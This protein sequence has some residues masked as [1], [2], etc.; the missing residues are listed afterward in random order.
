MPSLPS[1]IHCLV[2]ALF[3]YAAALGGSAH[4][5]ILPFSLSTTAITV[6][7]QFTLD[8]TLSGLD[9]G[10]AVAGFDLDLI[11][12][13]ALLTPAQVN[14][15][16]GLGVVDIDQFTSVLFGLGHIDFAAVSL[17]SEATLLGLQPGPFTLAQLVF[18]AIGAGTA[19]IRLDAFAAPG[20]LLSDQFGNAIAVT[21]S[22]VATLRVDPAI[23]VPEPPTV[24]LLM[25]SM[26]LA[27]WRRGA[28]PPRT[29]Q[30]VG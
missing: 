9:A 7:Q 3:L 6:G 22:D 19:D 10:Q 23:A 25:S 24:L 5:A 28:R 11:F 12:D 1:K 30:N 14:F 4:A 21:A 26:L 2:C 16:N 20:L 29:M 15:G 8:V 17:L 27:I 18:N 13:P